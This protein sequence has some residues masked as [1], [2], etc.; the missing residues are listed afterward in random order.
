[1][2]Y[3]KGI[4]EDTHYDLA[5]LYVSEDDFTTEDL[6]DSVGGVSNLV[7]VAVTTEGRY[8]GVTFE[9]PVK[10][11]NCRV[12]DPSIT[13]F[14]Y[15]PD[16]EEPFEWFAVWDDVDEECFVVFPRGSPS[17]MVKV[18]VDGVG[19]LWF[20]AKTSSSYSE[21]LSDIFEDMKNNELT[22]HSGK[23]HPYHCERLIALK[24]VSS[25][26]S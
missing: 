16:E 25:E 3:I 14:V 9:Q 2:K 6:F 17:G 13:A 7:F 8:F 19:Q 11:M 15:R 21:G 4:D 22:G 10:Q 23:K 1:M 26:W 12:V 18:G 20:G 24:L 5:L